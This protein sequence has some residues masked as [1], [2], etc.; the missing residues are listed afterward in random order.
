MRIDFPYPGYEQIAPV[1]VP[2][3][4]LMGV[5]SPKTFDD[6]DEAQVL[7]DGFARPHG[8]P[9]LREAVRESDRVLIIIDDGTRNT[10]TARILPFVFE[11]LHAAGVKDD[12]IEFIQGVGTHRPMKPEELQKKLGPFYGKHKVHE[13]HWLDRNQLHDF[14]KT[15]DGTPVTANKLVTEFDFVMGIGAIVPHRVKGTSGGAKI[16]F[17]GIA[18]PEIMERNQWE[19]SMHMSETVM[20]VPENP[21]RLRMEEAARIAGLKYVV[22]VVC[23]IKL[24]IVGCFTGDFV[25]AHRKGSLCSREVFAAHM[26]TRCDILIIDSHSAD[27]DFW[28]SAKGPYAGTM[29]VKDGG[30]MICVAPNPEGV[31]KNH[32][33]LLQIG[34]KPHAEIVQ[35]VHQGKVKD[36]VGVAILA[37][38]CQIVDKTDCIMVSP[39]VKEDE[40]R[41]LGFRYAPSAQRALEMAMDKQGRQARIA[42]LRYGGHILPVVDDEV[43]NLNAAK[44]TGPVS[45][46]HMGSRHVDAAAP[47]PGQVAPRPEPDGKGRSPD[48]ASQ[49]ASPPSES[50]SG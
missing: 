23:D 1:D 50:K 2:H 13:H 15:S 22:T 48:S 35:M 27:R 43:A 5:F 3:S 49:K 19:A 6:V 11:E 42:V 33:N 8:A 21:M 28:Q 24:H 12:R 7:R 30:S 20:G 44:T 34:Y 39:G 47:Q 32:E 4:N 14:G 38:V 10:P 9:R 17:P 25:E 29:A 40:A 18:G 46:H 45:A 26:P 16:M 36:L 31:A 41:K 37:D